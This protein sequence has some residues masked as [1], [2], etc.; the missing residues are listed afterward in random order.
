MNTNERH[1]KIVNL[2]IEGIDAA[3]PIIT[4]YPDHPVGFI[5]E[6]T[7]KL[8][9]VKSQHLNEELKETIRELAGALILVN[10]LEHETNDDEKYL[11]MHCPTSAGE[12]W[13][14]GVK[15]VIDH[16]F[17]KEYQM[18]YRSLE[19]FCLGQRIDFLECLEG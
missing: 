2:V 10:Y 1:Q 11:V 4:D 16:S 5:L 17:K 19:R 3:R 13:R 6:L 8:W 14:E 18:A 15:Q 9:Q 12:Y 7:S